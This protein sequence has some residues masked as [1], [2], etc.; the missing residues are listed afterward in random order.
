MQQLL[1]PESSRAWAPQQ[2]KPPVR[3][4]HAATKSSP[5]LFATRE[6]PMQQ[7]TL[8]IV[9]NNNTKVKSLRSSPSKVTSLTLTWLS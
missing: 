9:K 1:K 8:S 5:C 3:I 7:Q 4:L 6:K 2:E